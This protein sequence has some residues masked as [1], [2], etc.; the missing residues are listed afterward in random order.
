MKLLYFLGAF[1]LSATLVGQ[2]EAQLAQHYYS[3]GEYEKAAVLFKKLSDNVGFNEY[4]FNQFIESLLADENFDTATAEIK[5]ALK[6]YPDLL[7]LY[8]TYG[9][10]LERQGQ[11]EEAE[12]QFRKA[13]HQIGNDHGRISSLGNSFT[14][15]NKYELAEEVFLKGE[16]A[17]GDKSIF[18]YNLAEIY[19]RQNDVPKMIEYF[20]ISP[21]ASI[22]RIHSVQNYFARFLYEEEDYDI[23]Q[24]QLVARAQEEP[25]NLLFA[26]LIQ[27]VYITQKQYDRA[28]RQARS[29]DRRLEE[30]G[31]R[32]YAL[33]QIALNDQEY[34]TAINAFEYIIQEKGETCRYFIEAKKDLLK[35]KRKQIIQLDQND[36]QK[37][38]DLKKEY[39]S[40]LESQGKSRETALMILE[41]AELE[42]I[43]L[44]DLSA[45]TTT[46]HSLI[47]LPGMNNYVR[48]NA[49]LDLGDYYLMD[50]EIW[51]ATLLYSQVDK[52]FK[53]DFLGEKA[54]FKNAMLSYFNGDFEWAQEQFDILKSAT[55]KLISNDAIDRS[56]FI[57]DNANLDTS[58]AAL[59]RYAKAELLLFQN[60]RQE[61]YALL[62]GLLRDFPSH[63]L[64]DDILFL[65]AEDLFIKKRYE[66]AEPLYL[67]ILEQHADGIR[68]DNALYALAKISDEVEN[69]TKKAM[70]YYER[71]FLE[72]SDSTFSVDAR[73]RY[74]QLRGDSIQ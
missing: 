63:S 21:A 15:M 33:A 64:E 6:K 69:D 25:D 68:A 60:R 3:V 62:E 59:A 47:Q 13:I 36:Q 66:E 73:K 55:S 65:K 9:T 46:L 26:E 7:Q 34:N 74:R 51:E 24:Q 39:L 42:A 49:K 30:D 1:L 23:L 44:N 2:K 28:L 32:V 31:N 45:A 12:K 5:V 38:I 54:R 56:V 53:E 58:Y 14:N 72:Y 27:W 37:L 43:Y 4:Y 29:L 10:L 70:A 20:L 50:G 71:L 52:E 18:A 67:R 17:L 57:M 19:R 48:A 41:L 61:S 22:E 11:S 8:V 40:F 35:T 16:K